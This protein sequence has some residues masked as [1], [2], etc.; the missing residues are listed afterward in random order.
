MDV[1]EPI[2]EYSQLDLSKEYTYFD[3]LK[4]RFYER[5]EF[6]FGKIIKISPASNIKYQLTLGDLFISF[7]KITN[8]KGCKVFNVPFLM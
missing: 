2:T 5:V 8:P 6:V 4:W 1:K 7:S 3:Y